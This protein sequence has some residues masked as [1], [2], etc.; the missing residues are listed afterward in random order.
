MKRL[1]NVQEQEAQHIACSHL[2]QGCES[3]IATLEASDTEPSG[4][5][6][7]TRQRAH[8]ILAHVLSSWQDVSTVVAP[9]QEPLW[10]GDTLDEWTTDDLFAETLARRAGDGPA[11]RLMQELTLRAQLTAHDRT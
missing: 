5:R 1:S 4:D 3:A 7:R 2:V 11:L 8:E 6:P 10:D 9:R